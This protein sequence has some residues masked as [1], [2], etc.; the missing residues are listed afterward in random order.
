VVRTLRKAYV[1]NCNISVVLNDLQYE[2]DINNN[3]RKIPFPFSHETYSVAITKT[4]P[5]MSLWDIID[6]FVRITPN[7]NKL[8]GRHAGTFSVIVSSIIQEHRTLKINYKFRNASF[9]FCDLKLYICFKKR[10]CET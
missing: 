3:L 7:I 5:L 10:Y 6:S 9:R 4:S 8:C 2:I 1:I